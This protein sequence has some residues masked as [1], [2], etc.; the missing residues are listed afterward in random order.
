MNL[1]SAVET[2]RDTGLTGWELVAFA[3]RLVNRNMKYSVENS[4]DAP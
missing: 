1:H 2:C 4:L 3:Q